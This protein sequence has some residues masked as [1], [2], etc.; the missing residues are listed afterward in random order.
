M[1]QEFLECIWQTQRDYNVTYHNDMHCLDVTH[2]TYLLLQTGTDNFSVQ[3]GLAP[4]EQF[5]VII[6]AACHDYDHDGYNNAWH[7][8]I[9][10]ER[11]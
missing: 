8:K 11:F 6:A 9:Q 10:S 7:A 4:V 3:L 2:M 5:A 1:L